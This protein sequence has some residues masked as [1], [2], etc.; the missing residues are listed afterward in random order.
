[1]NTRTFLTLTLT[2]LLLAA[3]GP[4]AAEQQAAVDTQVA[5][6]LSGQATESA[7]LNPPDLPTPVVEQPQATINPLL[8][9]LPADAACTPDNTPRVLATV[10]D[11][12][13][14]DSIQVDIEGRSYEVRYIGID[15][16]GMSADANRQLVEGKQVLLITDTTDVDEYGRLPRYV[17]VDGIFVN[18]RLIQDGAALLSIE[19]PDVACEQVFENAQP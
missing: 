16:G 5:A 12:W 8:P 17:V 9:S 7:L 15:A 1:M 14:G 2:A 3:C 13:S 6:L 18:L 11:V 19:A 4:S 10:T